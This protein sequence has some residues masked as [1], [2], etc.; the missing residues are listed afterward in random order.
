MSHKQGNK[1]FLNEL[2]TS[3]KFSVKALGGRKYLCLK[4]SKHKVAFPFLNKDLA[5]F[6]G[7]LWGDGWVTGRRNSLRYGH[8]RIGLVEDDELI[9]STFDSLVRKVFSVKPNV[10]HRVGKHEI[11]FNSR[12]V[13]EILTR[14]FGFPDGEKIGR[15]RMPKVVRGSEI[16]IV[17][18]LQGIFSTDGKFVVHEGYPRIGLDSATKEFLD[19]IEL[20]LKQLGFKPRRSVWRRRQGN[21]LFSVYLNG[22]RQTRLFQNKIGFIGGKREILERYLLSVARTQPGRG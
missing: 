6:L 13:Y 2:R 9:I 1:L 10:H 22:I 14:I 12:V 19:D 15:L 18:F 17:A 11:Y 21:P 16:L 20:A 8:W 5:F 7:L 4:G 3:I